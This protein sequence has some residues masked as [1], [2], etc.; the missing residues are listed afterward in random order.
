MV[1]HVYESA[2]GSSELND[3]TLF[4][5]V[6]VVASAVTYI[7]E[8]RIRDAAERDKE[9]VEAAREALAALA[10]A[11]GTDVPPLPPRPESAPGI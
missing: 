5:M 9:I 2:F 3:M 8:I 7:A 10:A 11:P 6:F 4:A 1:L